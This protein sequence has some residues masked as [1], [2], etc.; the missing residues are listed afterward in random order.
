MVAV[1]FVFAATQKEI[2]AFVMDIVFISVSCTLRCSSLWESTWD[3]VHLLAKAGYFFVYI[4]VFSAFLF[5][6]LLVHVVPN[7]GSKRQTDVSQAAGRLR[8]SRG[9]YTHYPRGEV[10][11]S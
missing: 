8:I 7:K 9:I 5:L 6:C 4:C 3:Y 2:Q 11:I 1:S 10:G